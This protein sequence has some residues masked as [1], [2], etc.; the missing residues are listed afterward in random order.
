LVNSDSD[1]NTGKIKATIPPEELLFDQFTASFCN[2]SPQE[3]LLAGLSEMHK[4][5][6]LLEVLKKLC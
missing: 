2:E 6:N 3:A 5:N 1:E 4:N